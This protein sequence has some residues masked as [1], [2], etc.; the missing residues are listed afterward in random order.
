MKWGDGREMDGEGQ[1]EE[2]QTLVGVFPL[3]G[4]LRD[5]FTGVFPVRTA[6]A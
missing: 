2:A 5:F 1:V 4:V 3:R 6:R